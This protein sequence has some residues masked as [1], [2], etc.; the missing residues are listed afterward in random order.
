MKLSVLMIT[1][2][3]ENFIAQAIESVLMQQTN[4]EFEIV[5]GEDYSSDNTRNI[6]Q[7]FATKFPHK[8]K[9]ILQ[10][11]NLGL[12]GKNN[13][14]KTL[15][16]CKGQYIA[17]LEGDDYWS[18][19]YKLQKQVDFLENNPNFSMCFHNVKNIFESKSKESSVSF[20]HNQKKILLIEDLLDRNYIPTGSVVYRSGLF[21]EFPDWFYDI[22]MSDWPIWIFCALHGN[23][24]YI[25]EVMGAYRIHSAGVWNSTAEYQRQE[26]TIKMLNYVNAYLNFKYKNKINESKANIYLDLIFIYFSQRDI[27]KSINSLFMFCI[28]LPPHAHIYLKKVL[29]SAKIIIIMTIKLYFPFLYNLFK[30]IKGNSKPKQDSGY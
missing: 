24:W 21:H 14:V 12:Y 8:I 10:P 9:L 19:P 13:L 23:I 1:Y 28:L 6:V 25:D 30:F 26:E 27:K 4:F 2:N 7:E 29:I 15:K 20:P 17:I 3:H 18:D 16:A 11:Y 5:I 22:K